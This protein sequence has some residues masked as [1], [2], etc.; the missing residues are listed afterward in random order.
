MA[1]TVD[2][3]RELIMRGIQR[4]EGD[5][6]TVAAA[7]LGK[8]SGIVQSGVTPPEPTFQRPIRLTRTQDYL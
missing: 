8:F 3:N 1:R 5:A 2:L 7:A 6:S 4:F